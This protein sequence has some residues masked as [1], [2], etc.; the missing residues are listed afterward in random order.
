MID[1][2]WLVE[3]ALRSS[4]IL[5][6]AALVTPFLK[7]AAWR[8]LVWASALTGVLF[9]PVLMVGLPSIAIPVLPAVEAS[10]S[11]VPTTQ[12]RTAVSPAP[13][14][15]VTEARR[16]GLASVSPAAHTVREQSANLFSPIGAWWTVAA[17][18]ILLMV[19]DRVRRRRLSQSTQPFES[20][21]WQ[22]DLE[23]LGGGAQL[24]VSSKVDV[25]VTWGLKR[26]VIVLPEGAEHWS[27]SLRRNVLLHELAHVERC[28]AAIFGLARLACALHWFNPLAWWALRRVVREAELAADDRV[29]AAG[30]R[31]SS[32]AGDLVDFARRLRRPLPRAAAAMARRSSPL[33]DRVEAILD[34]ARKRSAPRAGRI[35]WVLALAGLVVLPAAALLNPERRLELGALPGPTS[36][37]EPARSSP[38]SSGMSLTVSADA[39]AKGARVSASRTVDAQR[40][41]DCGESR[42]ASIHADDDRMSLTVRS[43]NCKLEIEAEGKIEFNADDSGV[44]RMGRRARLEIDERRRGVRRSLEVTPGTDGEP[45]YRWFVDRKERPFDAE[46]H[47]WLREVLPEVFRSTGLN[48]EERVGRF[49]RDQGVAG[50]FAEI[51]LIR[52]DWVS[53]LYHGHL[54]QQAE[55]TTSQLITWIELAG[56]RIGSDYE[57]AE[58]LASLPVSRLLEPGVGPTFVEAATTIGSDYELRRTLSTLLD[59]STPTRGTLDRILEAAKTIGSDFEQAELLVAVASMYPQGESLP[60]SYYRAADSIG[61]DFE[62]RRALSKALERPLGDAALGD[63]LAAALTI[64]SDFELAEL[65]VAVGQSYQL[66][67]SAREAFLAA[68]DTVGSDY[69][70]RRVEQVLRRQASGR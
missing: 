7:S 59:S 62:L 37:V 41:A 5:A 2:S 58:T 48:A 22:R 13:S 53:R 26:P 44:K 30:V 27:P 14:S 43:A 67:G 68:L 69:E 57:L 32:Y 18:L 47:A 56:E 28:D 40:L 10:S 66:D 65:L 35:L 46:G 9:L 55:L 25:P 16:E 61:S 34:A 23:S 24:L 63:L 17:V 21:A 54:L 39:A 15:P 42:G 31:A 1:N 50:V 36:K 51:Q 19:G 8:H 4:L 29:L 60:E 6:F 33:E 20:S 45:N 38:R 70:H 64:G 52:S 49:L 3:L 11:T 12:A